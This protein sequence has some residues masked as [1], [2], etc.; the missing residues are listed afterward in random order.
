[1]AADGT[2]RLARLPDA[3]SRALDPALLARQLHSAEYLGRGDV[4]RPPADPRGGRG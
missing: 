3:A 1:V 2:V 4:H